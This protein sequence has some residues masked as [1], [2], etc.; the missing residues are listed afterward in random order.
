MVWRLFHSFFRSGWFVKSKGYNRSMNTNV[1]QGEACVLPNPG[2]TKTLPGHAAPVQSAVNTIFGLF[3]GG[4]GH[5]QSHGLINYIDTNAKCRHLKKLTLG[6]CV[7]DLSVWGP[8]HSLW[9]HT[10]TPYPLH[11]VYVHS[12]TEYLLLQWRGEWGRDEPERRL[13]GQQFTKLGR[14]PKHDRLYL[15]SI[16]SAKHL[17]QSHLTGRFFYMPTFCFGVFIHDCVQWSIQ[18]IINLRTC[19]KQTPNLK[20]CV[21]GCRGYYH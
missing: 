3:T 10:P 15:K 14:K 19:L 9:P 21:I 4:G 20:T 1:G 5:A 17:P 2:I 7:R 18:I 13:E 16:N 11:T 12:H 8:L 6:S